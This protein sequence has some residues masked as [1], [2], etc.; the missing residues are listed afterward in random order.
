[1]R[2]RDTRKPAERLRY[3]IECMPLETKRA[4]LDGIRANPIIVGAYVDGDGGVCPM[5]AAHRNGGRTNFATLRA[6]LGPLHRRARPRAPAPP[7]ARCAR[8]RRC[9]RRPS[10]TTPG[11][12]GRSATPLP[13]TT[14][15]SSG[16]QSARSPPSTSGGG[17]PRTGERHRG[18]SY[19]GATAGPGCACS[20]ATTT[21]RPR[22]SAS[23]SSSARCPRRRPP[24]TRTPN[25]RSRS[26]VH[27]RRRP[28]WALAPVR[29]V[30]RASQHAPLRRRSHLPT[31]A[32]P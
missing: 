14:R 32:N 7:S 5:L 30:S 16:A 10:A 1:M 11:S 20:A 26:A 21:T 17:P 19:A 6:R 31:V 22:S 8:S 9:S 3:A 18:A 23:T 28:M 15:S 4:M 13:S 12:G 29:S 25:A 24:R 2:E 27:S